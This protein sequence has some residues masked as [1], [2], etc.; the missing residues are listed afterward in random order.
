[1]LL[2]NG[3]S[4]A[5]NPIFAYHS[6]YEQAVALGLS[7]AAQRLFDYLGTRNFEEVMRLLDDAHYVGNLFGVINEENRVFLGDRDR[8]KNVLIEVI[9]RNHLPNAVSVEGWKKDAAVAFLAPFTSIFTSNYDLLLYW[10][11]MHGLARQHGDG[12]RRRGGELRFREDEGGESASVFYL[13]GALHLYQ[14]EGVVRKHSA[15]G[16]DLTDVISD[17]MD[18]KKYPLFVAEGSDDQKMRQIRGNYYLMFCQNRFRK[19]NG[20]LVVFGHRLGE[21][22]GHLVAAVAE[23][24][25]LNRVFIGLHGPWN[26]VPNLQV[27][28]AGTTIRDRSLGRVEIEYFNSATAGVWEGCP[29][30]AA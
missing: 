10:V 26:S 1:M 5:C 29:F 14:H 18:E 15:E 22:D 20:D 16:V 13:H 27:L 30:D 2:G 23:N 7:D 4:I 28:Q 3:F 21:S 9:S 17:A 8:L 6:L 25:Q 11:H 24:P 12:F 19:I